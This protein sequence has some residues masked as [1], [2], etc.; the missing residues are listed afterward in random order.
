MGKKKFIDKKN[1]AHFHLVRRSQRDPLIA[2]ENSSQFVL[3]PA[4]GKQN[5]R[6]PFV[7]FSM[8]VER[9]HPGS[10]LCVLDPRRD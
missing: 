5:V 3:I 1:S 9:V 2:D 4:G 8:N 7:S 6:P 10:L